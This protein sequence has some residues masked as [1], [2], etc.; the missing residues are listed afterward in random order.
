VIFIFKNKNNIWE[1]NM[2]RNQ[3][4]IFRDPISKKLFARFYDDGGQKRRLSLN[5]SDEAEAINR[6]PVVMKTKTSW[7]QYQKSINGINTMVVNAVDK[8]KI[9]PALSYTVNQ[10]IMTKLIEESLQN[11]TGFYDSERKFYVFTGLPGGVS[12]DSTALP[13][14]LNPSGIGLFQGIEALKLSALIDNRSEIE[15]FFLVTLLQVFTDKKR[16]KCI[17]T[18]WMNFLDQNEVKSW[19]Q[20]NEKVLIQ[21][22]EYR[23]NTAIKR[24]R[25]SKVSG[26]P[27]STKTLNREFKYLE[28]AFDEAIV[29]GLMKVNPIRNWKPD[30]YIVTPKKPLTI[31]E[32]KKVF[33]KLEGTIR[34]ICL[35]LF[36][37][38]KRRKEIVSL[39]IEDVHFS[40][41]YIGYIEYK[42]VS[43]TGNV[44]KAFYLTP[45]MESF[46]KRIIGD[47]VT[48]S[49]WPE[50]FHPDTISH[51]F[52][53]AAF[54]VAPEKCPTLKN[55]RQAATD[56]M[57]KSGGMSFPEIDITLGHLSVSAAFKYYQDLSTE[58]I[59][60]RFAQLTRK[61]VEV[62]S[63]SVEEY[64]K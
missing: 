60:R 59:Y 29:R 49:L 15:N 14:H 9:S 46:L 57:E 26:T 50:I 39:K 32:L 30:S 52:E 53:E 38:C 8:H 5:T 21:Y 48:G 11:G 3:K 25:N 43:R 18:I 41:H 13:S 20:I 34:D 62:L 45:S 31:D 44:H 51:E 58:A 37:S 7:A 35:L 4:P 12:T 36:V 24:G 56:Y 42:N 55:L 64:L 28:T 17:G 33:D 54:Q 47:R 27:P 2:G 22:K 19:M 40:E 10:E 23:K 61:G 16:V 1:I 6:L 63:S